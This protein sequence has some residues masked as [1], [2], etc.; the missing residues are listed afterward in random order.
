MKRAQVS[1]EFLL[2]FAAFMAFIT[3]F[4]SALP[5]VVSSAFFAMDLKSAQSLSQGIDYF[6]RESE[7]LGNGT[8]SEFSYQVFGE[9][10]FLDSPPGIAVLHEGRQR[11]VELPENVEV[12]NPGFF[13]EK[14]SL[15][16]TKSGGKIL[17][18]VRGV[19]GD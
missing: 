12:E 5:E 15:L 4:V 1:L 19:Q 16:A 10:A 7:F 18:R 3:V 14:I 11:L 17:V 9:W 8:S 6:S 13:S 2:V